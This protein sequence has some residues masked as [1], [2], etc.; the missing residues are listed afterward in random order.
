M[1][2]SIGVTP[3][4]TRR[5]S[6]QTQPQE[7]KPLPTTTKQPRQLDANDDNF[8]ENSPK[9]NANNDNG[10]PTTTPTAVRRQRQ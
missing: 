3:P 7:G 8:D 9:S 4:L 10:I 2:V 6:Q 5:R 1:L